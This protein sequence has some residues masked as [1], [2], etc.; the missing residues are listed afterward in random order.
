[1]IPIAILAI[2]TLAAV[3]LYFRR[4][5]AYVA[6]T[7]WIWFTIPLLRRLV[8][9][10][11]GWSE[12]NL[13]LIAPQLVTAVS[14]FSLASLFMKRRSRIPVGLLLCMAAVLYGFIVGVIVDPSAE[15]AYGLLN[16]GTPLVFGLHLLLHWRDYE[17]YRSMF[18]KTFL[19]TAGLLGAYGI[20]QYFTAPAWD[21]YWL[22]NISVGLIDPSFGQ[23][24][25]MAMRIW[26]TTNSPGTFGGVMM[27]A[28]LFLVV[29]PSLLTIPFAI[30]GYTAFLLSVVRAAWLGWAVGLV[31][32]LRKAKPKLM[33]RVVG[34]LLVLGIILVPV[35]ANM[36][37]IAP[38]LAARFSSFADLKNDGSLLE[39]QEMYRVVGNYIL[40]DPWGHGLRTQ[41]SIGNLAVDSGLLATVLSLGWVGALL[42]WMGALLSV[43]QAA[44]CKAVDPF[45]LACRAICLCMVAQYVGSNIFNS[46]SGVLFWACAGLA[47]AGEQWH[48]S[49]SQLAG[50]GSE[51]ST[52]AKPFRTAEPVAAMVSL[53]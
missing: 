43:L 23:P 53:H 21:A 10:K 6:Y 44:R 24:E 18:R 45:L 28:L 19:W 40:H 7:L 33:L 38:V 12:K 4:P 35:L 13:I 25:P 5:R 32:I 37:E 20:Y 8:D 16:W 48:A 50:G 47:L 39:R 49:E 11:L 27:T 26:S 29:S 34:S 15:V 46:L 31:L 3:Y 2:A 36:K 22:E 9:W 14:V 52:P 51:A 41:E 30:L 17:Q 42:Y 1:M